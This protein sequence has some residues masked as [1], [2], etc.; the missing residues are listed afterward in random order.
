MLEGILSL[1]KGRGPFPAVVLCHPHPLYGGD[2]NNNVI[3]A[4][5]DELQKES[6]AAFRFNFRG[7]GHSQGTYGEGLGEREDVR[8]TLVYL[9]SLEEIDS[10]RVG[11][12]GY[13][14]GAS[15][16]MAVTPGEESVKAAAAISPPLEE[17]NKEDLH[18]CSQSL[19][20]LTG[21]K[22]AYV[23]LDQLKQITQSLAKNVELRVVAGADHFWWGRE[24]QVAEIIAGFFERT[25]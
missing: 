25:L 23:P 13:S 7:V 11:V 12:A 6:I 10:G 15:V 4:M 21:D 24:G 22:D 16:A 14:F 9:A 1:P 5:K 20:F 2:M 19:L 17:L 18:K 3:T 8:A